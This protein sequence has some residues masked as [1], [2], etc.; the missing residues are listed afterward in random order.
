ML[1]TKVEQGSH[2]FGMA[3]QLRYQRK[4]LG[5]VY[6]DMAQ[7]LR[8]QPR[9]SQQILDQVEAR[10]R[11]TSASYLAGDHIECNCGGWQT[12]HVV[13]VLP[14]AYR[15]RLGESGIHVTVT[16]DNSAIRR[17]TLRAMLLGDPD[18]VAA[19]LPSRC[20]PMLGNV[21][22][23]LSEVDAILK[24]RLSAAGHSQPVGPSEACYAP[25]K[26]PELS[27]Q[28]IQMVA[29]SPY[30]RPDTGRAF[31]QRER[32]DVDR[33]YELSDVDDSHRATIQSVHM[34]SSI[35]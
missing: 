26:S 21:D 4:E 31:E 16:N 1:Y 19:G 5:Q 27:H 25:D 24:K 8:E 3:E 15:V 23:L 14:G 28:T 9:G 12:G 17:P 29:A 2:Y 22:V 35:S 10:A 20:T 30:A 32:R 13:E 7:H 11:T 33:R 18:H 34:R 6:F